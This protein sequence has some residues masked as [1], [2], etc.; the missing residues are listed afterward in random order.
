MVTDI[1]V[2]LPVKNL[3]KTKTFFSALGFT[4]N[5]QF[6]DEYAACMIMGEHFY[7]ML[8][9]EKFFKTFTKRMIA[10]A[11]DVTEVI[12]ALSVGSRKAVD[13]LAHK[14]V[15]AGGNIHRKPD[16]HG[17]MYSQSIED[18]DG[19]LWEFFWMDPKKMEKPDVPHTA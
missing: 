8:L 2:N 3:T 19:H 15:A 4:F 5:K 6:T 10:D 11:S 17:W 13:E 12:N 18:L 9:T 1:Y 14:A 16:D 7:A